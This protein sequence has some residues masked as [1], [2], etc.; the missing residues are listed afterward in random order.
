MQSNQWHINII[1]NNCILYLNSRVKIVTNEEQILRDYKHKKKG[2][3][4]EKTI[5]NWFQKEK[6]IYGLSHLICQAVYWFV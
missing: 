3:K 1:M 5:L 6:R 4:K 2:K